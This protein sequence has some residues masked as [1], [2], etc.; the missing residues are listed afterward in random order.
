MSLAASNGQR[1]TL[2]VLDVVGTSMSPIRRRA[3]LSTSGAA[4]LGALTRW[5]ASAATP[6]LW[7]HADDILRRI[8]PPTFPARTFDITV[9]V[10]VE[11]ERERPIGRTPAALRHG[12]ARRPLCRSGYSVKAAIL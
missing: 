10:A 2:P 1:D 3:F 8:V 7:S 6:D 4:A 9:Y 11:V 5:P 12:R